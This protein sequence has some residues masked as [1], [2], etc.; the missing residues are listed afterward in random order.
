MEVRLGNMLDEHLLKAFG[1]TGC[2]DHTVFLADFTQLPS[3]YNNL[4]V[5]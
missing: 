1:G 5:V 4:D 2:Y 3:I